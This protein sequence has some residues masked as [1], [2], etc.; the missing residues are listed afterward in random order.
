MKADLFRQ[1]AIGCGNGLIF[2]FIEVEQVEFVDGNDDV[3]AAQEFQNRAVAFGLR[4]KDGF[5]AGKIDA[6]RI[7]QDNGGIGGR[8]ARYHVAGVLFVS[9]RVGDDEFAL[10]RGEIAVGDVDGDALFAFGGKA[11]GEAGE[12]GRFAVFGGAVKFVEL[13]GQQGFAVVEQ[14]A[15]EGG[16]A[17]VDAAGSDEAQKRGGGCGHGSF[18]NSRIAC[19]FNKV[20]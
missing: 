2:G 17:V 10:G 9:G 1:L 13:V 8:C 3:G 5:A 18:L 11:V 19:Y 6:R 15:D 7:Y 12:V 16:F 14:A 20:V 4:Q